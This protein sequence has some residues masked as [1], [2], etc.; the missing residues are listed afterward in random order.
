MTRLLDE[1][2]VPSRHSTSEVEDLDV[3]FGSMCVH[4]HVYHEYVEWH[5]P[6]ITITD[7]DTKKA[8]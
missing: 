2:L 5:V 8:D 1:E 4:F 3:Q 6:D 7:L